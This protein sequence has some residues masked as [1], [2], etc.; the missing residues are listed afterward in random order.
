MVMVNTIGGP[1]QVTPLL[2]KVAVAVKVAVTG[3]FV[4]FTPTKAGI[5]PVPDVGFKPI[6]GPPVCAQLMVA[7][8]TELLNTIDG[9]SVLKQ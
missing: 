2:V 6:F 5:N 7:L 3:P 1:V 8:G 4:L 9:T